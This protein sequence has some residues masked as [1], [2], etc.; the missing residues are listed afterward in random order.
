MSETARNTKMIGAHKQKNNQ[1]KIF[2]YQCR[3]EN[4][5]FRNSKSNVMVTIAVL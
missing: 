2:N 4:F 3:S 1:T 5:K